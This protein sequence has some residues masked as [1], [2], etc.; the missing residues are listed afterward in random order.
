[1]D[2]DGTTAEWNQTLDDWWA[3]FEDPNPNRGPTR[4]W[5]SSKTTPKWIIAAIFDHFHPN[6]LEAVDQVWLDSERFLNESTMTYVVVA[7]HA[8]KLRDS[9]EFG[10]LLAARALLD[11]RYKL[12][13]LQLSHYHTDPGHETGTEA[14]YG[15]NA[16][17]EIIGQCSRN[18]P[19][20]SGDGNKIRAPKRKHGFYSL[21]FRHSRP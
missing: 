1:M 8:R 9:Y 18:A 16:F 4:K 17:F 5:S 21:H 7:M 2:K 6:K 20:G 10:G 19:L 12:Q 3:S 15:P 11:H 14:K 13:V